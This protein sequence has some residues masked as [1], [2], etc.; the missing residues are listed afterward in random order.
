MIKYPP[1]Q[2]TS[3]SST[4]VF[5]IFWIWSDIITTKKNLKKY[6]YN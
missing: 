3:G 1:R 6:S 2:V 5:I 4:A